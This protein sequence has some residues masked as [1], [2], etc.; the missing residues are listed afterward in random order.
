MAFCKLQVYL[1]ILNF[2][3]LWSSLFSSG[4]QHVLSYGCL[5]ESDIFNESFHSFHIG[6]SYLLMHFS[7]LLVLIV[8]IFHSPSS[9]TYQFHCSSSV[10]QGSCL[11]EDFIFPLC[12]LLSL[13]FESTLSDCYAFENSSD[14]VKSFAFCYLFILQLQLLNVFIGIECLYSVQHQ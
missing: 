13:A 3:L 11:V 10:I 14:I 5:D 4:K 12:K 8:S 6:F 7:L 9:L 1:Q 2:L